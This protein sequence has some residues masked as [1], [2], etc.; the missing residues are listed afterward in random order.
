[1]TTIASPASNPIPILTCVTERYTSTPR[2]GAPTRD[3]VTTI[4]KESIILWFTPAMIVPVA[5][6]NCT[7]NNFCD[8]VEPNA[9]AASIKSSG[10][11]LIPKSVKRIVGGIAKITD[12]IIPGTTPTPK[13]VIA[14]IRY[15]KA[16][17]VCIK[18]NVGF[19][20]FEKRSF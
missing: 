16:G 6:G 17:I 2:P 1:M 14:G 13:N 15:T 9:F 12:A 20:N 7:L 8:A 4:D 11:C 5:S 10:T 19:K 18:S 3:A